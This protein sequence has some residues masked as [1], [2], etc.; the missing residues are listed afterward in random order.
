MN[1]ATQLVMPPSL[2]GTLPSRPIVTAVDQ[3]Q[4]SKGSKIRIIVYA[5]AAFALLSHIAAYK[6]AESIHFA[7]T[8]VQYSVLSNESAPTLR[9]TVI[10]STVFFAFMLYLVR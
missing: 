7:V 6:I 4:K 9:G 5:T 10:M 8:N 2:M 3:S 1:I